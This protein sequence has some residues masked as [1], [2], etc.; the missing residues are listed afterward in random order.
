MLNGMLMG[1]ADLAFEHGGRYWVLDYKSNALGLDD[2]AYTAEAMGDAV[3]EHRYDVQATLYQLALHRLLRVRLGAA[4]D[5][6][7]HLGGTVF[8]FLRGM[9][10]PLAGCFVVP[11][12][13]ELI[14][15]LDAMMVR[16]VLEAS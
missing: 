9:R 2:A 4:Y 6:D 14:E 13:L 3:L 12:P 1:F 10:G 15:G 11:A 5:P 7:Q 16:P 8:M